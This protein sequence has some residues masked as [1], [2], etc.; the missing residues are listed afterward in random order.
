MGEDQT[1]LE[2]RKSDKQLDLKK[3]IDCNMQRLNDIKTVQELEMKQYEDTEQLAIDEKR[4]SLHYERIRINEDQTDLEKINQ[5]CETSEAEI[6][7]KVYE[8]TKDKQAEKHRI[9]N[10]IDEIDQ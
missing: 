3:L 4:K 10:Q 7:A 5:E 1:S 6:D 8:D 2:S 9:N